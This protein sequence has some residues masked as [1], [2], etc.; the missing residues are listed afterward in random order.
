M[1]AVVVTAFSIV[2]H[3]RDLARQHHLRPCEFHG[4]AMMIVPASPGD[5]A[6]AYALC[7]DSSADVLDP[8]PYGG[9]Q[10]RRW[11]DVDAHNK[12]E[13][14]FDRLYQR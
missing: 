5:Q 3:N 1:A 14:Y 12:S 8:D 4:V 11:V 10:S 9:L 13:G 2:S 7:T 6:S